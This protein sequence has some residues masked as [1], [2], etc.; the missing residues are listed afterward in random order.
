MPLDDSY[1]LLQYNISDFPATPGEIHSLIVGAIDLPYE[2]VVEHVLG[3]TDHG[4]WFRCEGG[5][6]WD[7]YG[8]LVRSILMTAHRME[9]IRNIYVVTHSNLAHN[10]SVFSRRTLLGAGFSPDVVRTVHYL[11]QYVYK[12]KPAQ[13]M[14]SSTNPEEAIARTVHLFREHPLIPQNVSVHGLL[15]NEKDARLSRVET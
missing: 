6:I 3:C 11:L 2:P 7:P 13:W 8:S 5:W 15:L 4:L 1:D 9:S 14:D 10:T 12:V